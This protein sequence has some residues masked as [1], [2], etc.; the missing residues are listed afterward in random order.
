[1]NGLV[2]ASTEPGVDGLRGRRIQGGAVSDMRDKCG[3]PHRVR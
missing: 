1:M 3:D 2:F